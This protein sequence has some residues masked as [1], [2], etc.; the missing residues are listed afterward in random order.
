MGVKLAIDLGSSTTKIYRLGG[1]V[2]LSEPSVVALNAEG[3]GQI[4]A[5]GLDAKR[6]IGKT[7]DNTRISFPIF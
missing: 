4:R 7:A 5:I 2:L 6:I 1:G 3:D